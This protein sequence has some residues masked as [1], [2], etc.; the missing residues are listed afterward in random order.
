MPLFWVDNDLKFLKRRKLTFS[1]P[2]L[3]L[4]KKVEIIIFFNWNGALV[5]AAIF[6]FIFGKSKDWDDGNMG[7]E[8]MLAQ[9]IWASKVVSFWRDFFG[10]G[11]TMGQMS[12]Y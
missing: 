5:G 1:I 2:L 4:H 7:I 11:G 10:D 8:T 9:V 12:F 6:W 3:Q